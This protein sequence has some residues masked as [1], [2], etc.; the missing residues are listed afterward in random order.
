MRSFLAFSGLGLF[1]VALL[2]ITIRSTSTP[3]DQAAEDREVAQSTCWTSV[4]A[5]APDARFP[6]EA[7]VEQQG[8]GRLRLS[9]S[10]DVG[11][12]AQPIR[13]NYE[14]LLR[15]SPSGAYATDSVVVWQSH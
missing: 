3:L 15:L 12:E 11:A 8:P 13:R 2:F 1:L 7:S 9:G 4:R 5:Q 6:F 14:C 10:V